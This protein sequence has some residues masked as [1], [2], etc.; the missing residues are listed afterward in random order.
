MIDAGDF[1]AHRAR[2]WA[3]CFRMTGVAADADELVQETFVR[4]I[5][6]PPRDRSRDLLPWLVRVATNASRDLLRRRK[7]QA[8]VGPWLPS[9]L[10]AETLAA[11]EQLGPEAHYGIAES[12]SFAFLIAL[13]ALSP[14]QRAV[15]VLRDVLGCSVREV[16]ELLGESEA[17]VKTSHHRARK[18]LESYDGVRSAEPGVTLAQ[19]QR[20]VQL[21]LAKLATGD[22]ATVAS[23]LA[24]DAVLLNDG[25]GE[26]LAALRPIVSRERV[27]RF[28]VGTQRDAVLRSLRPAT[29][30]GLPALLVDAQRTRPRAPSRSATLFEI[31]AQGEVARIYAVVASRKLAHLPF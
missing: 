26:F 21:L 25:G 16:S 4:A 7:T 30:G 9:P 19:A 11:D 27:A 14:T 24:S 3:L 22:V 13:E 1:A 6:T 17:N 20:A 2:L 31:D 18:A 29:L 15:L 28:L 12:V 5:E 10:D 8:Y 23:A